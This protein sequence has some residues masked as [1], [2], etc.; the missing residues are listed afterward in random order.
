MKLLLPAR[1]DGVAPPL[2][3]FPREHRKCLHVAN[4]AADSIQIISTPNALA[5][6]CASWRHEQELRW[7]HEAREM[8]DVERP[9]HRA[10]RWFGDGVARL[11][12]SSG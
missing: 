11:V 8:I 1:R 7:R 6:F 2:I 9:S 10:C 4:I 12:T 3:L 5:A